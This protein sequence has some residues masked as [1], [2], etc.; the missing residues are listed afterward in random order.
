MQ[1]LASL[2]S[3][4]QSDI[5]PLEELEDTIDIDGGSSL[6]V[7][8]PSDGRKMSEVSNIASQIESLISNLSGGDIVASPS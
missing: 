7:V 5:A 1:S 3:S 6:L 4:A 2:M 8:G